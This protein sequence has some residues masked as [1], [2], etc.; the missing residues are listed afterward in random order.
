MP[1]EL[2]KLNWV[3]QKKLSMLLVRTKNL[4]R[5]IRNEEKKKPHKI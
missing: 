1:G 5:Q 4:C 3:N 2:T